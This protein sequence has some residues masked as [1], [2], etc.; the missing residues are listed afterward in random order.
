MPSSFSHNQAA[1]GWFASGEEDPPNA[2][3]SSS[4]FASTRNIEIQSQLTVASTGKPQ[5]WSTA[6]RNISPVP[7]SSA[8]VGFP[9]VTPKTVDSVAK[10]PSNS[11]RSIGSIGASST[12]TTPSHLDHNWNT[13]VSNIQSPSEESPSS[14]FSSATSTSDNNHSSAM[15]TESLEEVAPQ[16]SK[17]ASDDNHAAMETDDLEEVEPRRSGRERTSTTINVDGYAVKRENNY[18]MK[19]LSYQYGV[20]TEQAQPSTKPAPK[21]KTQQPPKP[22]AP[23][24]V[25]E[26]ELARRKRKEDIMKRKEAKQP[27]RQSFLKHHMDVLEPFLEPKVLEQIK[28]CQSSA[29][30]TA[31]VDP[32]YPQPKAITAT[33][34]SYQL[35]G[36]NWMSKMYSKNLGFILGDEMGLGKTIQTISLVCHLKERF[37]TTGPTLVVCPLSVLYSWCDEIKKW[38]PSLK[39]YRLHQSQTETMQLPDFAQFDIIVTTYEMAK[40]KSLAHTWARQTFNLL[41]LDE[42]HL[43]KN[44][45]TLVSQGVRRIHAENRIILTGTPLANNL[46]ELFALLNFLNPTE[47]TNVEPFAEA[48]DLTTNAINPAALNQASKLLNLFMIRRLK[49][50]VEKQLLP[51]IET[52]VYCPLSNSQIY[53]YKAL[54]LKDI[55]MLAG[56]KAN[57]A[58]ALQNLIMQLRK[59]VCHPYLFPFAEDHKADTSLE[60]LVGESG[61]LAVLDLLLQSLYKKGHRVCIF[62]GFTKVLDILD[63]YCTARGWSFCRF[64]GSTSR[65]ERKYLIDSFNAPNSEKFLFLMSTRSG[66]MGI[67]LQTADTV[68]LYDSDWNPQADLQAQA[69]VHR[70]GQQKRVF[71]YRMVTKNTVEERILQRAEKKLYLDKMVMQQGDLVDDQQVDEKK[72]ME[73]LRFGAQAVF[74]SAGLKM[75]LPS[76]EDIEILTDRS[77]T[78]SFTGGKIKGDADT[79]VEDFDANKKFRSTTDFG[80]IDFK[81]IRES[82]RRQKP[83]DFGAIMNT[84]RKKRERKNRITMVNAKGSGYGAAVPVLKSN[85]YDLETGEQSVFQRELGGRGGNFGNVKHKHLKAGVDFQ[86]QDVC[87]S[88]GEGGTLLCC[89]R[90]PVAVCVDCFGGTEKEFMCCSHHHCNEC[91]KGTL[92]AGGFMFRCNCCPRAYC[93]DHLPEG[94]RM[95]EKCER[96][97]ELGYQI[98]HGIYIHCSDTCENVAVKEYGWKPPSSKTRAVCPEPLDISSFYGGQIDDCIEKPEDLVLHGKRQRKKRVLFGDFDQKENSN[99]VGSLKAASSDEAAVTKPAPLSSGQ[100][101]TYAVPSSAFAGAASSAFNDH[102]KATIGISAPKLEPTDFRVPVDSYHVGTAAGQP[103]TARITQLKKWKKAHGHL[104]VPVVRGSA[105]LGAWMAAQRSLY[106]KGTLHEARLADLR[107]LGA[108]G[109]GG[110]NEV[111]GALPAG[112]QTTVSQLPHANGVNPSFTWEERITQL[113]KWKRVHGHFDIRIGQDQTPRPLGQWLA[114]QRQLFKAGDMRMDRSA[115]LRRMGVPG[116]ETTSSATTHRANQSKKIGAI[117]STNLQPNNAKVGAVVPSTAFAAAASGVRP[118]SMSTVSS[119]NLAASTSGPNVSSS[120]LGLAFAAAA[121]GIPSSA[122]SANQNKAMN[123]SDREQPPAKRAKV[124]S[125]GTSLQPPQEGSLYTAVIPFDQRTGKLGVLIAEVKGSAVFLGYQSVGDGGVPSVAELRKSFHSKY[126]RIVRINGIYTSGCGLQHVMDLIGAA[127]NSGHKVISMTM[128]PAFNWLVETKSS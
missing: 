106:R 127:K 34:R 26:I 13:L 113:Q 92:A 93:E 117:V 83:K 51:K 32:I 48:Y 115:I 60:E 57:K 53:F 36:L 98:K 17:S 99:V 6:H 29:D 91:G 19:G 80:G 4:L 33:M 15:E 94:S 11:N 72:L 70:L 71:V 110:S 90:C 20:A 66:G 27:S 7:P 119:G 49:S 10:T 111:A 12:T 69:R 67:N 3:R 37:G 77:R 125:S 78:E 76:K 121:A 122:L 126:D 64:D 84:W 44:V 101:K 68:I 65:A 22:R 103:P 109:F 88:C 107:R 59:C 40:A 100:Q 96:I 42:G 120:V 45:A 62:S 116:F 31:A 47:F 43:I 86:T 123:A 35:D 58:G 54:L 128:E 1:G 87:Q 25:S 2:P 74:G 50:L 73:T 14:K 112:Q 23:A 95:L 79:N 102:A 39:H 38:A 85:D 124:A 75:E 97:E 89:P 56:N 61:K 41:V 21:A 82:H 118:Q 105:D 55:S 8:S 5:T 63:D 46:T 114:G 108:S 9:T 81:A 16:S 30:D 18:I 24:V 104:K 52:K 28:S